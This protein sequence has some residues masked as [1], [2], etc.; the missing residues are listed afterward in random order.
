LVEI[1]GKKYLRKECE[2]HHKDQNKQNNVIGNLICFGNKSRHVFYH[3]EQNRT[4][5]KIEKCVKES[6]CLASAVN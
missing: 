4:I 1:D 5:K 2:V 3:H 6:I